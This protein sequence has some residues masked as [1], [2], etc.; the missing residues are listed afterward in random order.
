MI[1]TFIAFQYALSDVVGHF[2]LSQFEKIFHL[3]SR[4]RISAK[5][6]LKKKRKNVKKNFTRQ[7]DKVNLLQCTHTLYVYVF[8]PSIATKYFPE[9]VDLSSKHNIFM[10]Q[11]IR[12]HNVASTQ[13]I[14]EKTTNRHKHTYLKRGTTP[15]TPSD[16]YTTICSCFSTRKKWTKVKMYFHSE[17]VRF[18]RKFCF[19]YFFFSHSLASTYY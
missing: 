19:Q 18:R 8:V 13:N 15:Q 5:Y 4:I 14:L 6:S 1:P 2:F 7:R 16:L 9:Y 3:L 11:D 12:S 17:E 10:K